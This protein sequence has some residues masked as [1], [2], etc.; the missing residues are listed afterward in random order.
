MTVVRE[1]KPSVIPARSLPEYVERVFAKIEKIDREERSRLGGL[2]GRVQLAFRVRRDGFIEQLEVRK[3][4][5]DALV[6]GYATR[7]VKASEPF[8]RIPAHV[9][10]GPLDLTI[11]AR[12]DRRDGSTSTFS[13]ERQ[14]R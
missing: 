2:D 4:S 14:P 1:R 3:S 13:I 10:T 6:D 11:T 7:I 9:A 8:E 5:F 12:F